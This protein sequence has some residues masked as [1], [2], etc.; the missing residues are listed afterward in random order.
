MY[1]PPALPIGGLYRVPRVGGAYELVT[2]DYAGGALVTDGRFLYY[3]KAVWIPNSSWGGGYFTLLQQNIV[4]LPLDG[5][6]PIDVP[7]PA[8]VL[9]VEFPRANG[10]PGVYW[11]SIR[12]NRGASLDHW[13]T[14]TSRTVA[15]DVLDYHPFLATPSALYFFDEGGLVRTDLDGSGAQRFGNDYTMLVQNVGD[16]VYA[17]DDRDTGNISILPFHATNHILA[18]TP[19]GVGRR[20]P[21]NMFAVADG[22]AYYLYKGLFMHK[23]LADCEAS[24]DCGRFYPFG[25]AP[26]ST[27]AVTVSECDV[28]WSGS[29]DLID[30]PGRVLTRSR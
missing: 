29:D 16:T 20:D 2:A 22:V 28:Y 5:G 19:L 18:P 27:L 17:A 8:P 24:P 11:M 25:D 6:A 1:L 30:P 7:A 9:G 23:E 21:T 14:H 13:D 12:A 15:T 26:A 4:A 10:R 3:P